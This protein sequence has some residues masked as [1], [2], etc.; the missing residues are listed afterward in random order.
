[1]ATTSNSASS[2]APSFQP[3]TSFWRLLASPQARRTA[4]YAALVPKV[5]A[6]EP[7]LMQAEDQALC[8]Q[9]LSLRYRARTGEPM[10]ELL[11]E[12]FA[13][14][15]EAGRRALGM[16]HYDVQLLGGVAMCQRAI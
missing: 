6:L 14:V 4:R 2:P 16:R 11:P 3:A 12:A 5:S 9:S 10:L 15:R 7:A 8:K 13:L 1:M